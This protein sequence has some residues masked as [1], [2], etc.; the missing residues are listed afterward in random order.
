MRLHA[1]SNNCAA[2]RRRAVA[3]ATGGDLEVVSRPRFRGRWVRGVGLA[4]LQGMGRIATNNDQRTLEPP[5]HGV[6]LSTDFGDW[7]RLGRGRLQI[8]GYLG[9][10]ARG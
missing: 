3:G 9:N 10:V 2:A 6:L 4:G 7:H 1:M 5:G 8:T